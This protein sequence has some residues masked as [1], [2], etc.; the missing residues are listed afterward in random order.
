MVASGCAMAHANPKND[1]PYRL[2]ISRR[3]RL[4]SS[5]RYA[6]APIAGL[7]SSRTSAETASAIVTLP[8]ISI[9]HEFVL[10]GRAHVGGRLRI[11]HEH[12]RLEHEGVHRR[13]HEAPVGVFGGAHDRL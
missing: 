10:P 13:P 4:T 9:E 5:S 1:W 3:V 11:L 12:E 6:A 8:L 7:R 2:L